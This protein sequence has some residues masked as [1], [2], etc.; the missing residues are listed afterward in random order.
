MLLIC[1]LLFIQPLLQGTFKAGNLMTIIIKQKSGKNKQFR[2]QYD[3]QK[4]CATLPELLS[5]NQVIDILKKPEN[6]SIWNNIL[7]RYPDGGKGCGYRYTAF[8][9]VTELLKKNGYT[10]INY[11]DAP[12]TWG[13]FKV[14]VWERN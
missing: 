13:S 5:T 2:Y 14:A 9:H 4:L 6:L 10:R 3:F 12:E 7:A 11:M 1:C 8:K